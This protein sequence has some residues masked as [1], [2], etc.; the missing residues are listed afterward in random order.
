MVRLFMSSKNDFGT[1]LH[2]VFCAMPGVVLRSPDS[3]AKLQAQLVLL[4]A[5]TLCPRAR[6]DCEPLPF[7]PWVAFLEEEAGT[8]ARSPSVKLLST[9]RCRL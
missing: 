1:S 6:S 3:V 8:P 5:R 9:C 7:P 2:H 4:P